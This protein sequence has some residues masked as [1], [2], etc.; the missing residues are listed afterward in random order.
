[1][2]DIDKNNLNTIEQGFAQ[3]NDVLRVL[4]NKPVTVDSLP[5]RSISGDK[6]YAGKIAKYWH[7]R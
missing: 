7:K 1:M 4:S 5:D 2:S 3:L 6:I